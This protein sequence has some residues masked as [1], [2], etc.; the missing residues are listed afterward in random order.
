[1]GEI[2]NLNHRRNPT[3]LAT[4]RY[5]NHAVLAVIIFLMDALLYIALSHTAY[6]FFITVT[7][8]ADMG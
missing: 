7:G 4:I 2:S 3:I 6:C 5:T 1:M 8:V